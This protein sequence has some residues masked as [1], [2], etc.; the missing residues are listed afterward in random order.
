MGRMSTKCARLRQWWSFRG[1][2]SGGEADPWRTAVLCQCW[3]VG[4]RSPA[5]GA[6]YLR[7][8][9]V[10]VRRVSECNMMMASKFLLVFKD[11]WLSLPPT[12]SPHR[13]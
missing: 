2:T 13:R 10:G 6:A 9:Q 5:L 3:I 1:P 11:R 4:A 7:R 12:R 8:V